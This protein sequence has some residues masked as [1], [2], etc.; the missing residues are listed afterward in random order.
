MTSTIY[1]DEPREQPQAIET[2]YK[3]YRFRRL[4]AA[5]VARQ[6]RFEHGERA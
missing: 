1:R 4:E 3:S 2:V 5:A 6:A